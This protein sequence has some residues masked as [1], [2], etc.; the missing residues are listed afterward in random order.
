[1]GQQSMLLG[2]PANR[3]D[4]GLGEDRTSSAIRGVLE[5]NQTRSDHMFVVWPHHSIEL[6]KAEYPALS[7]DG[8]SDKA[9]ELGECPLLVVVDMAVGLAQEFVSWRAMDTKGDL[10]GHGAAGHEN[11]RFFSEQFCGSLLQSDHGG[12]DIDD[13]ITHRSVHHCS[14]HFRCRSGYGVTSKINHE[15]QPLAKVS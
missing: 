2:P 3:I 15:F 9:A 11:R 7:L 6:F 14:Q 13:V 1:M 10:V 8:S 4:V 12:I 5:A